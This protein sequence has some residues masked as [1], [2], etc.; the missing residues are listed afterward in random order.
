MKRHQRIGLVFCILALAA[1][2]APDV[3]QT[4]WA[5]FMR[6]LFLLSFCF[7]SFLFV[8]SKDEK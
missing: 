5:L 6:V 2:H 7:G 4:F 3:P 1:L 8:G